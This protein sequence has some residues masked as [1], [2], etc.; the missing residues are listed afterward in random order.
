MAPATDWVSD[1][2][3]ATRAAVGAAESLVE[4]LLAEVGRRALA[5]MGIKREVR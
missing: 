3:A 4:T 5:L 2:R 1:Q